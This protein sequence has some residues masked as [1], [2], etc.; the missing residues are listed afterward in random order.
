[1][2]TPILSA[3]ET[4]SDI[5]LLLSRATQKFQA[6]SSLINCISKYVISMLC[7]PFKQFDFNHKFQQQEQTLQNQ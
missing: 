3:I 7:L 4:S 6:G 2:Q 5:Y 1:M